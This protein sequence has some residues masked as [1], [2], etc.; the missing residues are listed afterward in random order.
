MKKAIGSLSLLIF[1]GCG[2]SSTS[3]T[4]LKKP[5]SIAISDSTFMF[6]NRETQFAYVADQF[7]QAVVPID[8]VREKIV[9]VNDEDDFDFTPLAIGGEPTAVAVDGGVVPHRVFVADQESNQIIAYEIEEN[10]ETKNIARHKP[11]SLGGTAQGKNSRPIFRNSGAQSSPTITNVVVDSDSEITEFWKIT[12]VDGGRYEVEGSRSGVQSDV[13]R[14]KTTYETDDGKLK[15]FISPGGERS[16]RGDVFFFS[17]A[18]VKPLQLSTSPVDLLIHNRK[19]YILTKNTPSIVVFDLDNLSIDSTIVLPDANALPTKMFYHEEKIYVSNLDS[20]DIF[21]FDV[22]TQTFTTINT[23]LQGV[24]SVGASD[25]HLFLLNEAESV[26]SVA[27]LGGSIQKSLGLNDFGNV[28]VSGNV[29]GNVFGFVPNVSGNVDV[30]DISETKRVDTED[31]DK[32]DYVSAEFFDVGAVSKPQLISVGATA[33]KTLNETWQMIFD[34]DAGNYIVTGSR[35]GIQINR[36]TPGE[37]YTSDHGEISLLTRPSF[38]YPETDG[39]FFSFLSLD[40]IDPIVISNQGM[41]TGGIIFNRISDGVPM[42]YFI[43]QTNGQVSVVD[44][45][46]FD[47][48]KSL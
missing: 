44:L 6:D 2:G 46:G 14:E 5:V 18:V 35:S 17:T 34:G 39:D 45:R 10:L 27:S 31:N 20:G 25:D 33:G 13:A 24:R 37:S 21:S 48:K 8:T 1:V 4:P 11:L 19:L 3:F 32:P 41:A 7:T 26:L 9:D 16:T 38:A 28:F 23:S 43:Q 12:Y 47:V 30:I 15:F 40:P 42:G 22:N 29:N 36:V